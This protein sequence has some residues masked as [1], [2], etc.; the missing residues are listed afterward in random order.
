M[1]GNHCVADV[2]VRD[3]GV[4]G[5][6]GAAERG[7]DCAADAGV[8][9]GFVVAVG[10]RASDLFEHVCEWR[11]GA[12]FLLELREQ[13]LFFGGQPD[14]GGY[15][16]VRCQGPSVVVVDYAGRRG[17]DWSSVAVEHAVAVSCAE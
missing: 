11:R 16:Y 2:G 9:A 14:L 15:F 12:A 6:R 10:G 3:V 13:V 4:V 5:L 8:P 1:Q 7:E 17:V